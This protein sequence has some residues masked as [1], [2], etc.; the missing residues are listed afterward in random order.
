MKEED[1]SLTKLS[2][3]RARK[4]AFSSSRAL[5]T[6]NPFKSER[7]ERYTNDEKVFTIPRNKR[8]N[9]AQSFRCVRSTST[10][11]PASSCRRKRFGNNRINI[12]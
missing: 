3:E 4:L 9:N 2:L 10:R 8:N 6:T 1:E 5:L 11:F 7:N 12:S